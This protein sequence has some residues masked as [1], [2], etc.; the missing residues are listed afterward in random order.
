MA[1]QI[2]ASKA[3]KH[4]FKSK[5][6]TTRW[7]DNQTKMRN[8]K[9]SQALADNCAKAHG[10]ICASYRGCLKE[11]LIYV[12]M[13]SNSENTP[14]IPAYIF[15]RGSETEYVQGM[16]YVDF[17]DGVRIRDF[18]NGRKIYNTLYRKFQE[19]NFECDCVESEE[20]SIVVSQL[21]PKKPWINKYVLYD[22][23]EIAERLGMKIELH[24]KCID[25]EGNWMCHVKLSN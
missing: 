1:K 18:K 24:H 20:H 25:N 23:L 17:L 8:C 4:D 12:P 3:I 21:G 7:S 9:K 2:T 6:P 14:R 22:Y 11:E 5:N 15:I 19:K 16:E 10:F 13:C